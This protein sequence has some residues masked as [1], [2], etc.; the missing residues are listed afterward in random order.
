[1]PDSIEKLH[2]VIKTSN[3]FAVRFVDN[4]HVW[5][6]SFP[7]VAEINSHVSDAI[8][9]SIRLV[10][11]Q[12][13]PSTGIIITGE[14]GL[15]KTQVVSRIR[16]HLQHQGN[17]FFVYMGD[18]G[19]LDRLK[20]DFQKILVSSL[21][22]IGSQNV[23]QWQELAANMFFEARGDN[24]C[25]I[26]E[27]AEKRFY[28]TFLKNPNYVEQWTTK[29]C[30]K[31]TELDNPYLVQ[32][33]LWTLVPSHAPFA[34]SWLSGQE[35]AEAKAKELGLPNNA[36]NRKDIESF[37]TTCQL[38]ELIANYKTLVFCFDELDSID[39]H[40]ING[41][42]RSIEVAS[43]VKDIRNRVS[44]IVTILAMYEETLKTR[45]KVMPQA[46]AVMDRIGNSIL[47]LEFLNA[48]K[49]VLVVNRWIHS[50]WEGLK[51]IPPNSMYPI[52]EKQLRDFVGKERLTAR[53]VLDWCNSQ[54]KVELKDPPIKTEIESAYKNEFQSVSA[55]IDELIENNA[56]VGNALFYA[57][58]ALI[59]K[60]V[61]GVIV[62]GVEWIDDT[63]RAKADKGYLHLRIIAEENDKVV[64]IGVAAILQATGLFV[65]AALKRLID[66]NKFNFTR[67]C[68][69]RSHKIS[70]K[71]R[72]PKECENKLLNEQGGEWASLLKEDIKPLIAVAEMFKK[73]ENYGFKEEQVYGYINDTRLAIDN[74]L[75]KEI[76][77]SPS[78]QVPSGLIDDE[79]PISSPSDMPQN[80]DLAL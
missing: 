57:F 36:S 10:N 55:C 66:Y 59:G 53:K 40:P 67:G 70:A 45:I 17:T 9:E 16:H 19:Q 46:E 56:V 18:Y 74:A 65:G 14:K 61:E 24:P 75:V 1:M 4:Q 44:R 7:D 34:L 76:L 50:F 77:S 71:A 25:T 22:K 49:A 29:I 60:D 21:K 32:A 30:A 12:Q 27:L 80:D 78:G 38:M 39:C 69:V 54:W 20:F 68:L 58:K 42:P 26:Q 23:M 35:L 37:D 52:D 72:V 41:N 3:P 2:D 79:A 43:L 31:R 6:E 48:D 5:G 11:I 62:K 33:I 8:I 47:S 13:I 51:L 73:L 63:V 64:K 28:A 15:G